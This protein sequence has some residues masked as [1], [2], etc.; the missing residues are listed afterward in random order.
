MKY[1]ILKEHF[2]LRENDME[3]VE[4]SYETKSGKSIDKSQLDD[5]LD[6][7][8][9]KSLKQN[10]G[11]HATMLLDAYNDAK[12]KHDEAEIELQGLDERL[13]DLYYSI[14]EESERAYT[15]LMEAAGSIV[16]FSK[17]KPASEK[18]SMDH[19][20]FFNEMTQK[21]ATGL[22]PQLEEVFN[23][24][25]KAA[26]VVKKTSPKKPAITSIDIKNKKEEPK[27]EGISD[28]IRKVLNYIK[29]VIK[30]KLDEAQRVWDEIKN[31]M[32]A[33]AEDFRSDMES[34][35]D[36]PDYYKEEEV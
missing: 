16:T 26:M 7:K 11:R 20:I 34:M 4:T 13:M 35:I 14:S 8:I 22:F 12:K 2:D 15:I 6:S 24:C 21:M 3:N 9:R 36:N 30:P 29:S 31:D 18:E 1:N 25:L 27:T 33:M 32:D 19:K 28:M 17:R 10:K 23:E 5:T